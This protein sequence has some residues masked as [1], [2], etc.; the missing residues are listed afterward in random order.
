M[1]TL[2]PGVN[3]YQSEQKSDRTLNSKHYQELTEKRKLPID[4]I[5]ENCKSI[6]T[7]QATELLGYPAQSPGIR[8]QGVSW[9]IQF[10]P[11]K[12]WK[13]EGTDKKA[14]KYRTPQELEGGYDAMLPSHPTNKKYWADLEALKEHC[15][16]IDGR[17]Y[18]I[19]TE[20]F[21]K[22]IAGCSNGLPTIALLGVEMGLTSAK[23]DS[24]GKRYLVKSLEKYAKAGFGFIIA[25]D[26]DC[27]TNKFV[28]EAERKLVFNL[29]MFKVPV[30]SVTGTWNVDEGKGM[31]DFIQNQG[32]EKFRNLLLAAEERRYQPL[33]EDKPQK[34]KRPGG[35]YLAKLIAD[36]YREKMAWDIKIREWRSYGLSQDGVWEIEPKEAIEQVVRVELDALLLD[37]Y[38]YRQLSDIMSLLKSDLQV[39][40]WNQSK[41]YIPLLNGVLNKK[42]KKLSPHSPGY[43]LTHCLPFAYDP[44][45]TCQP[46]VDWLRETV[47][48]KEDLEKFL[49][50]YLNAVVNQ[51]ADLQRYLELIGPGGTGKSTY[52]KLASYLV[53]ERNVHTTKHQILEE[54]RFETA[55]L[56]DKLLTLITEADQY[57]GAVS[58]LKAITGQDPLHY[59]QK[60]K[61]AGEGFI[62]QGMVITAGNE[63]SRSADY[64]SGLAR[65]KIPVWFRN[66]IPSHRRRDLDSEFKQYLPG[67][68][69]LVLTFS[70]EEVTDLIRNAE[71]RC[72]SLYEY[73][74][75]TLTET[76]PIADWLDN[77]VLRMSENRHN[78]EF[79]YNAYKNYSE[80]QGQK[81]ISQKRFGNLLIDLC[82]VQLGWSD[83]QKG[84]DRR[85]RYIIGLA[86][87]P[88]GDFSPFPITEESDSVT[89]K[90]VTVTDSVTD[91]PVTVTDS[92]TAETTA[93]YGC[94]GCDGFLED[95][96]RTHNI[97]AE[98]VSE[99]FSP[100]N[101]L[102]N[103]PQPVTPVTPVTGDTQNN[104][105]VWEEFS[106]NYKPYPNPKSDNERASQNRVSKIRQAVQGARTKEDLSALRRDNGGEFSFEE[107]IWVQNFL[108]SFFP[109]EYAHLMA[110]KEISQPSLL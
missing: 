25:F 17:P 105:Q 43:R 89:D 12:P 8:L 28:I 99:N 14:P 84:R 59:E 40:K 107:L 7:E 85:G 42:T 3:L 108:K 106:R 21:F 37:G 62:Y 75:E 19:I 86:L 68:L 38:S 18:L 79:L 109:I 20:G 76:N 103:D 65:R 10:K 35:N 54:S 32:V 49:L 104:Q 61:Q 9:Q 73:Q 92:V 110:V 27:A 87:R 23:A 81:P 98:V 90:P 33:E 51:R 96:S 30:R 53:G 50:A 2:E 82:Q 101:D 46:I 88:D 55:N 15:W 48:H 1:H 63:P 11:D 29:R 60:M 94:D 34:V 45:A 13:S 47:G 66:F 102:K 41:G 83:V 67:L 93:V 100:V 74:R 31:D 16:K 56:A 77:K 70:D 4:W 80:G 72:P 36:K 52:M 95:V 44:D 64:T 24:Q 91:K 69:N 6:S 58:I 57:V 78:P 26:A 5:L 97:V 22:A 71:S 39:K